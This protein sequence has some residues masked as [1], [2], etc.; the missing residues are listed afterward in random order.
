[1]KERLGCG[2]ISTQLRKRAGCEAGRN[3][4]KVFALIAPFDEVGDSVSCKGNECYR[5]PK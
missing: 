1:M 4:Y 3:T 5:D 2:Y